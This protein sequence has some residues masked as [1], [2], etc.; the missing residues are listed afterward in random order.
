MEKD[1]SLAAPSVTQAAERLA[2]HFVTAYEGSPPWDIDGPQPALVAVAQEVR[3]AV[4]DVGCGTGENALF[5][6]ARGHEVWGVDV[7]PLAIEQAR[8]KSRDRGLA[9]RFEVGNALRLESLGRRF[10]TLM[11]SGLF[12]M[13]GDP[14]RARF[15]ASLE[16]ALVPG[17]FCHILCFGES[18]PGTVGPRAVSPEEMR[19]AFAH[20]WTVHALRE[21][22]FRMRPPLPSPR[23]WL[24]S[25]QYTP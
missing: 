8:A 18:I 25:V 22:R 16:H 10:E 14:E 20:G 5:F 6:A 4:L 9:V 7:V 21:A 2:Q 19:A 15:I 13:F 17:G 1:P 3:G 12:H 24:T 23:A 11:D